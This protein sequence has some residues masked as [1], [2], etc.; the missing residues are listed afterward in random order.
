M[1]IFHRLSTKIILD[2]IINLSQYCA[3]CGHSFSFACCVYSLIASAILV[4][5]SWTVAA[6][7]GSE[8]D[9]KVTRVNEFS[10]FKIMY[11]VIRITKDFIAANKTECSASVY[12]FMVM[13]NVYAAH[14]DFNGG[15]KLLCAFFR[16]RCQVLCYDSDWMKEEG[17]TTTPSWSDNF[18]VARSQRQ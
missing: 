15:I 5:Y 4:P 6:G 9:E 3:T 14:R 2:V 1:K 17:K 10:L 11:Y 18:P 12:G 7:I 13:F 8:T 16:S